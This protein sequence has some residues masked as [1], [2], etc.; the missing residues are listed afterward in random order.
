MSDYG[1]DD[2]SDYGDDWMYIED[3]YMPADDL[4]E[5]AVNS[6]ALEAVD[7]HDEGDF[8]RFDYFIDLDYASD[9][10]DDAE[11]YTHKPGESRAGE[12]RKRKIL[13]VRSKKKQKLG[14]GGAVESL[15]LPMAV[16]S[17]VAWYKEADR[18]SKPRLVDQDLEPYALMKDWREQVGARPTLPTS[19]SSK[20]SIPEN[21]KLSELTPAVDD[22]NDDDYEDEEEQAEDGIGSE[23]LMAAIQKNL[24]AAG[25]PLNGMDPQQLLQFAM[26]MMNN[27]DAGDD[28][29]GELADD[30]LARGEDD[31]DEDTEAEAPSH[32]LDWLSQHRKPNGVGPSGTDSGLEAPLVESQDP[33]VDG[34]PPTPP[35]SEA[36]RS[37]SG[38]K[39]TRSQK[40]ADAETT[41]ASQRNVVPPG[42]KQE[43]PNRKRKAD[44][45]VNGVDSRSAPKKRATR[46][47]DA[48][49]AAS[50]AQ[51][52]PAPRTT[53]TTRSKRG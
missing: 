15:E 40:T 13:P 31:A 2:L 21:S 3:E 25:G 30:M 50:Q 11:F 32:L 7:L 6:P 53:R 23:A 48:P 10:Y 43:A 37:S 49:T 46:T 14:D 9:G 1:D 4:A 35:L 39:D 38:K 41:T 44:G 29:A 5:H 12:K 34:R 28:I 36:N 42:R 19:K 45:E 18:G 22:D 27:Q 8:D 17:P 26:R 51:V 20:T 33:E 24:A 16:C 47:F 52:A